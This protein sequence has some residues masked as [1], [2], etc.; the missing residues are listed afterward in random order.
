MVNRGPWNFSDLAQDAEG[1][2]D[3]RT[4]CIQKGRQLFTRDARRLVE[5]CIQNVRLIVVKKSRYSGQTIR[6]CGVALPTC[7]KWR[8]QLDKLTPTYRSSLR[9]QPFQRQIESAESNSSCRGFS[10]QLSDTFE[11]SVSTLYL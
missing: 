4:F 6:P 11:L 10:D 7:V 8:T 5:F 1:A 3:A 2:E 9:L